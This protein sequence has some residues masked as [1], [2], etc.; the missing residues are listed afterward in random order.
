VT[1]K[2]AAVHGRPEAF[3]LAVWLMLAIVTERFVTE[4]D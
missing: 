3:A 2:S 4:S 1:A